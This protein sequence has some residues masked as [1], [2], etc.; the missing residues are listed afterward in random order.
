MSQAKTT[1]GVFGEQRGDPHVTGTS[2][3]ENE[4]QQVSSKTRQSRILLAMAKI[5]FHSEL[6]I[7]WMV[8]SRV[9]L[10]CD[11]RF[12]RN[13]PGALLKLVP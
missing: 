13:T 7:C 9:M 12:N 10:G 4:K 8:S 1:P 2:N 11:L 6:R 3:G 5:R